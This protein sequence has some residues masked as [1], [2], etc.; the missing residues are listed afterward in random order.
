[1]ASLPLNAIELSLLADLNLEM[2]QDN[3]ALAQDETQRPE[4]RHRAS[5]LATAWRAR[6][7]HFR[8]QAQRQSAQ[9]MLPGLEPSPA[10]AHAYTGPERRRQMRRRETRR[11][12]AVAVAM[13][14]GPF[15]RRAG[16]ERR[17]RDR[18]RPEP[19]PSR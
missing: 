3:E 10:S 6:A 17:G 15:D 2:A 12:T 7:R 14:L 13:R 8:L 9:P 1:M 18:R 4:T 5:E 11:E 19:Q 16:A